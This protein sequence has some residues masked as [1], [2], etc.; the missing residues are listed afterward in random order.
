MIWAYCYW[1]NVSATVIFSRNLWRLP[2]M[3]LVGVAQ[4]EQVSPPEDHK[5]ALQ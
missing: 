4:V 5:A 2:S 1:L 3:L